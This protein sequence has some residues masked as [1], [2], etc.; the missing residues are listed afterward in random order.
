MG[1]PWGTGMLQD[2]MGT[3]GC[4]SGGQC[5]VLRRLQGSCHSMGCVLLWLPLEGRGVVAGRTGCPQDADPE[6]N[7]LESFQ[8][9]AVGAV[10][11]LGVLSAGWR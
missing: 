11:Q 2:E 1:I 6:L 3:R 5:G 8:P 4:G 7:P 10:A 9:P